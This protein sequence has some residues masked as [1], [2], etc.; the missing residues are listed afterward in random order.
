LSKKLDRERGCRMTPYKA[1]GIV[2]AAG[3]A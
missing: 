2:R 1:A 3:D